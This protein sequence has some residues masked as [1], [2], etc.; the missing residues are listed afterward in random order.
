MRLARAFQNRIAEQTFVDDDLDYIPTSYPGGSDS[1]NNTS[2]KGS[3]FHQQQ[4]QNEDREFG[5]INVVDS[6]TREIENPNQWIRPNKTT[7]RRGL[8]SAITQRI[9]KPIIAP[10]SQNNNKRSR[11]EE[12]NAY[13]YYEDDQV[14]DDD[15]DDDE[16][17]HPLDEDNTSSIAGAEDLFGR[18]DEDDNE[19]AMSVSTTS[20][21]SS[22][23]RQ[24]EQQGRRR[25]KKPTKGR[26]PRQ[27]QRGGGFVIPSATQPIQH[28]EHVI[29]P[30]AT[31]PP[32]PLA[33]QYN[34]QQP[35]PPYQN[36]L[37]SYSLD[38]EVESKLGPC[39]PDAYCFGC[40]HAEDL[41]SN[42]DSV[43]A[44]NVYITKF[45]QSWNAKTPPENC[46]TLH[47]RYMEV[48]NSHNKQI[49]ARMEDPIEREK[50]YMKEWSKRAIFDHFH[51]H[52]QCAA[53]S[54]ALIMSDFHRVRKLMLKQQLL[55]PEADPTTGVITQRADNDSVK[56]LLAV[57]NQI[58]SLHQRQE[59]SN[60]SGKGAKTNS[61]ITI[62]APNAT[63]SFGFQFKA[64]SMLR[65]NNNN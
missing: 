29:A 7:A 55:P 62:K 14:D 54:N 57:N 2:S 42:S 37:T 17:R 35:P 26:P 27:Q 24:Q 9:T 53:V 16:E 34:Q 58:A 15:E 45:L 13:Q 4:Q 38:D 56:L 28:F 48:M 61:V 19:D 33:Y 20:S 60:S 63:G 18:S 39:V 3:K 1:T 46:K 36:D 49:D 59:K 6:L 43:K 5:N 23:R 21:S 64:T 30:N 51:H 32:M 52:I 50:H 25:T 8:D 31:P 40:E 12:E 44:I 22:S 11:I 47:A 41:S 10:S 65:N